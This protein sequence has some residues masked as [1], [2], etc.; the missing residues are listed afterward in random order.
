MRGMKATE[1]GSFPHAGVSSIE[2]SGEA[3]EAGAS[4]HAGISPIETSGVL[5]AASDGS[6]DVFKALLLSQSQLSFKDFNTLHLSRGLGVVHE[7]S[8]HRNCDALNAL[9]RPPPSGPPDAYQGRADGG[10]VGRGAGAQAS[11]GCTFASLKGRKLPGLAARTRAQPGRWLRGSRRRRGNTTHSGAGGSIATVCSLPLSLPFSLQFPRS[12]AL[13]LSTP[14]LSLSP[15]TSPSSLHLSLSPVLL[16]P[17]PFFCNTFSPSP[18]HPGHVKIQ[19][20]LLRPPPAG[21]LGGG[22]AVA[23][24]G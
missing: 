19:T 13:S 1:A 2:T 9:V 24:G 5:Q 11:L 17:L 8:L 12:L 3:A 14:P 20:T 6:F 21:G 23:W 16:S 10:G 7:I 4:P 18:A 22:G 15:V